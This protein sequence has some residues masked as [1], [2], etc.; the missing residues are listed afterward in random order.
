MNSDHKIL[1]APLQS[2]TDFRFRKS[3]FKYFGGV[4]GCYAP[5]IK[6]T[7]DKEIKKAQKLDI[8]PENNLHLK[9]KPQLMVNST[10]DYLQVAN[11]VHELGYDEINWNMGCPYP[12]VAKRELGAGLLQNP[13]RIEKI[14]SEIYTQSP[15][16][17]G[18]KLRMGYESTEDILKILPI[19]NKY[20]LTEVIIHARF[21]KQLYKPGIDYD[22]FKEC[23]DLSKHPLTFNGDINTVQDFNKVKDLFPT[24]NSW[25]VGRGVVS[26]PFLPQM[27]K[28]NTAEYPEDRREIFED[29]H[30]DLFEQYRGYLSGDKQVL[31]KMQSFWEYFANSFPNSHKTYKRI[32]KSKTLDKYEEEVRVNLDQLSE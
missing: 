25:M 20:P 2:F 15:I 23:I 5:Y 4:D 19:F 17:L 7:N 21:A 28:D 13:D 18:M 32:K 26:D 29:F 31:M 16:K 9:V 3:Y 14:L 27:I 30:N 6:L 8:L 11:F 10:E 22:R 24:I 12:M 1:L